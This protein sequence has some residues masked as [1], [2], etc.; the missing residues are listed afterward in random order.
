MARKVLRPSDSNIVT[1]WDVVLFP[2]LGQGRDQLDDV[3]SNFRSMQLTIL[4]FDPVLH[5]DRVTAILHLDV[6]VLCAI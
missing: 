6:F 1:I 5:V 4:H 2:F 3:W